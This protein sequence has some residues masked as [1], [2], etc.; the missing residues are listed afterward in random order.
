MDKVVKHMLPQYM[1]QFTCTGSAC[2]DT[3]CSSWNIYIDKPTYEKYQKV[4]EPELT[5][6]IKTN[7]KRVKKDATEQKYAVMKL[8]DQGFC[9]FL[10]EE[11][12]C[13]IQ[14][15]LGEKALCYTCAVYPRTNNLVDGVI[16]MGSKL[17]CPET[18]RLALLNER[19][20]EFD[21]VEQQ[22]HYSMYNNRIN[23]IGSGKGSLQA[24][25]WDLRIFVISLLQNRAYRFNERV[26]L[27]GMFC[28]KLDSIHSA[29]EYV[30]IPALLSQFKHQLDNRMIDSFLSNVKIAPHVSVK[31]LLEM[32]QTRA[33]M[34]GGNKRYAEF[35]GKTSKGLMLESGDAGIVLDQYIKGLNKIYDPFMVKHEYILEN[36]CVNY[37]FERLFLFEKRKG[38][39]QQYIQMVSILS[40]IKFQLIGIG[41]VSEEGDLTP[42]KAVSFIQSFSR[43]SEHFGGFL[44]TL[45]ENVEQTGLNSLALMIILLK[46]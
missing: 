31:L 13:G 20:M 37:V 41:L 40:L 5:E 35:V 18:A 30:K 45:V 11:K 3:C 39:L 14:T 36:Y 38:I 22:D 8:D 44:Q 33:K 1:K 46:S 28:E 19:P 15:K 27:L 17:S 26:I 25:F 42:E 23:T 32:M 9:S 34:G 2:E 43:N 29:K 10:S 16:E 6:K 12:L 21:V 4:K 24:Y 7:V